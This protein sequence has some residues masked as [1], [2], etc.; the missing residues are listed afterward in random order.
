MLYRLFGWGLRQ[1][2]G[3][4]ED[5]WIMQGFKIP[6]PSFG[7]L[8]DLFGTVP[9]RIKLFCQNIRR[10]IESGEEIDLIADSTGLRFGKAGH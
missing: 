6:F 10:R 5:L 1:I 2:S 7:H 9:I 3:Y 4:V 8:S